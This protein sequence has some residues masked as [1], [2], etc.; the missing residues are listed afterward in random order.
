MGGIGLGC[1]GAAAAAIAELSVGWGLAQ[2]ISSAA[3]KSKTDKRAPTVAKVST[4][5]H[6]T[7]RH[8]GHLLTSRHFAPACLLACLLLRAVQR[9]R[10]DGGGRGGSGRGERSRSEQG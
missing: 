6:Y 9:A 8:A 1:V 3:A 10:P 5:P 2:H 4:A 7:I